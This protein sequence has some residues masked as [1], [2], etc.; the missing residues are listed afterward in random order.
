MTWDSNGISSLVFW[1]SNR[2][3]LV[4]LVIVSNRSFQ[5]LSISSPLIF[6]CS[7]CVCDFSLKKR[8]CCRS[9]VD[10]GNVA[11]TK[12][13]DYSIPPNIDDNRN[14]RSYP[15]E[16]VGANGVLRN[17]VRKNNSLRRDTRVSNN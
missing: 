5:T 2:Y 12:S 8:F 3:Y 15:Y 11:S 17:I 4:V 1:F 7:N 9:A 14:G 16:Y 13:N 6:F 10:D